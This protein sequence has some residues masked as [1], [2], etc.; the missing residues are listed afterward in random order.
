MNTDDF[1]FAC[2]SVQHTLNP[3]NTL[4]VVRFQGKEAISSPFRYDITLLDSASITPV[5]SFIGQRATLRISTLSNPIYKTV[6]GIII[7]AE[8]ISHLP[9]G[10]TLRVVLAPPWIRAKHRKNCRIFLEKTLRHIIETVLQY[11]PSMQKFPDQESTL[12]LGS[13]DFSPAHERFAWRIVDAMRLDDARVRPYVVQYNESDFDFVSRLLESEGISYHFEHGADTILLVLTDSDSGRPRLNPRSV[14]SG[15]DGREIRAFYSGAA[16]RP[17]AVMIGDYNWKQPDVDMAASA[18]S[19]GADLFERV[20]P[21]QYPD[22][23]QQGS[24]LAKVR[25]DRHASEAHFARGEGWLRLLGAA[26]IFELEH[27]TTRL[28]GEYVVTS[29]DVTAEQAGVLQSNAGGGAVVPF[30]ARF[31]CARRGKGT[32][33]EDSRFRPACTTPQPR[34]IG[35]QTAIVTAEPS[36]SDAEI[37]VGGPQGTDI[38]CVRLAFHWDTDSKRRSKESSSAWVRVNE[39]FAGSGSGGVWH[40]RV[41]TEVIVAFEDGHPDR[42]IVVG[43]VYNGVNRPYHGGSPVKSTFKSN[44]SPGG[45]VHNE[46]TFDDSSG[47]ELVYT[48]A[49]KDMETD[50]GNDRL[51]TV[52]VDAEMNVGANDEETIGAN[53]FVGVGIDEHVS[54]KGNDTSTIAGNVTTTIGGNCMTMIGVHELHVV[55]GNQTIAVGGMHNEIVGGLFT[56]ERF[57]TLTTTVAAAETQIVGGN[58]LTNITAENTQ[59]FGAAHIKLVEGDRKLESGPQTTNAGAA[60]VRIIKGSITTTVEGSQTV[61]ASAAIV[62]VAPEYSADDGT[63]NATNAACITVT[64][65]SKTTGKLAL[66]LIGISGLYAKTDKL[67]TSL[68]AKIAGLAISKIGNEKRT[69]GAEIEINGAKSRTGTI[70]KL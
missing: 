57:G 53:C 17:S 30:L 52:A 28:E 24:P 56:E 36:A 12:D 68:N 10:R 46:I 65:S 62:F 9:E 67:T 45:A 49:G 39:P 31:Q 66:G 26:T 69:V 40:P 60:A 54:V 22:H 11:D 70:V 23:S 58:R 61:N 55:G 7:E 15:I 3:W 8:E 38:G 35:T 18:G 16:L 2:E 37:N 47:A 64:K 21:G 42:P 4:R 29:L 5:G 25:L 33:I 43:R 6:H 13:S 41:G 20:F 59:T 19:Q 32:A 50:V 27:K 44:S 48:N 63:E 1:T 14:G 34:I 51:E